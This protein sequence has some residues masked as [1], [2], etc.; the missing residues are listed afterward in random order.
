MSKWLGRILAILCLAIAVA[1][2]VA[3]HASYAYPRTRLL[4]SRVDRS[5]F[6]SADRGRLRIWSQEIAPPPPPDVIVS[7]DK[8]Y[9]ASVRS[10]D[11]YDRSI[12]NWGHGWSELPVWGWSNMP[13]G[14]GSTVEG[15]GGLYVF[16]LTK[17]QLLLP[18][19]TIVLLG[20]LPTVVSIPIWL[21]R[22][23]RL[24]GG[25]CPL[26]GCDLRDSPDRCPECGTR[27]TSSPPAGRT[28]AESAA[29]R[30][31]PA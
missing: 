12:F 2:A 28:P 24:R 3:W 6:I 16:R 4:R 25:R 29:A 26:C 30:P 1:A 11:G 10:A 15:R 9:Q 13:S 31:P 23:R 21:A 7:L 17:R 5:V 8:P 20:V 19:W 22:R 14:G 18:L 27:I